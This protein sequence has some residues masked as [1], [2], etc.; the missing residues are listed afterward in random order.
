MLSRGGS[1][2]Q[3][4]FGTDLVSAAPNGRERLFAG[5]GPVGGERLQIEDIVFCADGKR[6]RTELRALDLFRRAMNGEVAAVGGAPDAAKRIVRSIADG[7]RRGLD[8]YFVAILDRFQAAKQ[9]VVVDLHLMRRKQP[10]SFL[11]PF[12]LSSST[13]SA[14]RFAVKLHVISRLF[15]NV[16]TVI[17]SNGSGAAH[18]A[19]ALS[20][21]YLTFILSS[22]RTLRGADRL[23][24][25]KRIKMR[26]VTVHSAAAMEMAMAMAMGTGMGMTMRTQEQEE[27]ED[28]AINALLR[29]FQHRFS[30]HCGFR[31][32]AE[33]V[34]FRQRPYYTLFIEKM[35]R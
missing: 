22:L 24:K 32:Y 4:C 34:R 23:S 11:A 1:G 16:R 30:A 26:N 6:L 19:V 27:R 17:V 10:Y 25:L 3:K 13:S 21:P 33:K 12:F 5:C 2:T 7:T 28:E 9:V 31:I 35:Q 29:R 15:E 18:H 8:R 14:L 20:A